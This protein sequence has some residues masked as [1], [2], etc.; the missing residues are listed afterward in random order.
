MFQVKIMSAEDF[1]F[2]VQLANTMNWNMTIE[3]F[4][5]NSALEPKGCFVLYEDS[6]RAGIATSISFGK[7]GWFGNLIVNEKHRKQGAGTILLR[8]ALDYL[9]SKGVETVGLYAYKHLT[10]F[11][12]KAGFTADEDFLYLQGK[13]FGKEPDKP[14][15]KAQKK[16]IP[17]LIKFDS[18]CF[19][20]SREKLLKPILLKKENTCYFSLQ[21][22]NIAGYAAVKV[23]REMAEIGPLMC[24]TERPD[25]ATALLKAVLAELKDNEVYLC[26]PKKETILLDILFENGF[27]E[28]FAVSRMFLGSPPS[29]KCITITESLERG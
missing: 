10:S 28:L 8:H 7:I 11:Y 20:A 29:K 2:A 5:I 23:Y 21:N 13:G 4:K 24:Q 26:L 1:P 16:D 22:Q 25:T 14:L 17:A 19:G 6:E 18:E 3:D 12:R 9:H 27:T 15:I